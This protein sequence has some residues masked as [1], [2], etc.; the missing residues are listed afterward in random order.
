[1]RIDI[2]PATFTLDEVDTFEAISNLTM[3]DLMGSGEALL[4][5]KAAIA[6]IV[7]QEQ[8]TNPDYTEADARKLKV[9]ELEFAEA[10]PTEGEGTSS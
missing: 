8:R 3:G 9:N 2:D 5:A 10:D 7:V 4:T 6:M 1:M